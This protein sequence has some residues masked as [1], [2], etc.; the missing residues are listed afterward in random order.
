MNYYSAR[1]GQAWDPDASNNPPVCWTQQENRCQNSED[2]LR[3]LTATRLQGS[4][5]GTERVVS[6]G[7]VILNKPV[8]PSD[9]REED[10]ARDQP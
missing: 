4:Q 3:L 9:S 5:S 6:D 1:G 7:R 2:N 8:P 10:R